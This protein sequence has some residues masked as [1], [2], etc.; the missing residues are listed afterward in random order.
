M[1]GDSG[2]V[3]AWGF[4]RRSIRPESPPTVVDSLLTGFPDSMTS[5]LAMLPPSWA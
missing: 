1:T 3:A 2:L 4:T 5:H